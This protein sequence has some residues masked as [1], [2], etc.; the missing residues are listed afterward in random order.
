[1]EDLCLAYGR[2]ALCLSVKET[3]WKAELHSFSKGVAED[4][5]EASHIVHKGLE[6][7][8]KE[9]TAHLPA[10]LGVGLEGL[11]EHMTGSLDSQ[12]VQEQ[13]T[14]VSGSGFSKKSVL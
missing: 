7:F 2:F 11:G 6:R 8:P 4:S 10:S 1:M 9:A 13:F 12:Q 5:A 3:D 14:K